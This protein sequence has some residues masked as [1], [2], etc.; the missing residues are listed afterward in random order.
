MSGEKGEFKFSIDD[1]AKSRG[2]DV[3]GFID[4]L[5]ISR[6]GIRSALF[7]YFDADNVL[8]AEWIPESRLD[9]VA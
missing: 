1:R 9:A 8:R 5:M 7:Q 2:V 6:G 4:G 3:I